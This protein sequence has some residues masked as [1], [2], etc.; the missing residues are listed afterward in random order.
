[1]PRHKLWG[2]AAV[3][4]SLLL[5]VVFVYFAL[6]NMYGIYGAV[7]GNLTVISNAAYYTIAAP[8]LLAAISVCGTGFWIGLT[9]LSIRV[10]PPM[11]ELVEKKDTTKV[12]AVILC[13]F[14]AGAAGLM[15]YGMYIKSYWAIAVPA[16]VI[17]AVILGAIFWVGLAILTARKTLPQKSPEKK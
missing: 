1:M 5:G 15:I 2:I 14:S 7:S 11:P 17:S 3:T 13:L 8:V 12:K 6:I 4:I 10:V 9:I 16:A